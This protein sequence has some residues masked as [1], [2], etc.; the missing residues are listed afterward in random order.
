[1]ASR[2]ER[3]YRGTA[4]SNVGSGGRSGKNKDLYRTIYDESSYTNIEG[5]ATLEK[6]NEIDLTKIQE[7]LKSREEYKKQ[8]GYREIIKEKPKVSKIELPDEEEEVF[9]LH[10]NYDIRDVLS[11]AKEENPEEVKNKHHSLDE[12]QY[13]ILKNLQMKEKVKKEDYID[14]DDPEIKRLINTITNTSMLNKLEDKELSLDLLDDLKSDTITSVS[15]LPAIHEIMD[16]KVKESTGE[17]EFDKSFFT[18]AYSFKDDDF[19]IDENGNFIP[20]KKHTFLK[21]CVGILILALI[22]G[23]AYLVYTLVK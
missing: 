7:M 18:S 12:T 19:D 8:R 15:T 20:E 2:M 4:N 1:M 22:A 10:R 13:K 3:Y 14:E 17:M 11:K 16:E 6:T 21:V 9:D 5:I 23:I